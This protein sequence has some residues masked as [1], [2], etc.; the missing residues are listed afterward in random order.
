MN[1][2][3]KP[4]V[5]IQPVDI[6]DTTMVVSTKKKRRRKIKKSQPEPLCNDWIIVDIP[7]KIKTV[8]T[9]F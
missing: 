7:L 5:Y 4:L 6:E 2:R 9:Y 3:I 1:L 8:N